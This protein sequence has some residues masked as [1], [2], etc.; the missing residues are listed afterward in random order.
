MV[1][2]LRLV[3]LS[4]TEAEYCITAGAC[5]EIVYQKRLF[6]AFRLEFPQQYPILVDNMS[7][8]A[9]AC[10]PEVHFQRTKHIDMKYH[11]QR[12]LVL[13]GIVRIKHQATGQLFS[14]ILTKNVGRKIHKRHRDVMFG[15]TPVV[16]ESHKLPESQ[17][18]YVRRHNDELVRA[19]QQR[20]LQEQFRKAEQQDQLKSKKPTTQQAALKQVAL[21]LVA[22]L[23]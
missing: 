2:T 10:G 11:Y 4:S 15:R 16:I 9:I 1:E 19:Q 7:A 14:D 23:A 6:K 12:Q 8:I 22:L 21:A 5:K 20:N 17:K 18:A 3:V 13:K